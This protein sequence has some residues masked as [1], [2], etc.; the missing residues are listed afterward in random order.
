M[1]VFWR[2]GGGALHT[3]RDRLNG[4][5]AVACTALL[6]VAAGL[7]AQVTVMSRSPELD[8]L[9]FMVGEWETTTKVQLGGKELDVVGSSVASWNPRHTWLEIRSEMHFPGMELPLRVVEHV[10]W[11]SERERYEWVGVDDQSALVHRGTASWNDAGAWVMKGHPF[12]WQDGST[13]RSRR[14]ITRQEDGSLREV[15]EMAVD[16]RDFI[17]NGV[18]TRRPRTEATSGVPAESP[19]VPSDALDESPL[20]VLDFYVGRIVP[21]TP[22]QAGFGSNVI[23]ERSVGGRSIRFQGRWDRE[24]FP[25]EFVEGWM[26]WDPVAAVI[27]IGAVFFHGAT[28]EGSVEVLDAAKHVVERRWTG[29]YP[30]GREVRYRERWTPVSADEFVW[31]I[32]YFEDGEWRHHLPPGATTA[33]IHRVIRSE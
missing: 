5:A 27:K 3:C 28:F 12:Q 25:K 14:T 26:A 17:T 2:A 18:T 6:F 21:A 1:S 7:G 29:H 22:D 10:A 9:Q 4:A 30:D 20:R 24:G 8:R 13:Y 33:A 31:K 15:G 23:L 16:D 32:D 19:E 11:S